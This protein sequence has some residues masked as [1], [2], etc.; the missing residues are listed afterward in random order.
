MK[1]P[2]N[3]LSKVS[4]LDSRGSYTSSLSDSLGS[5]DSLHSLDSLMGKGSLESD[6]MLINVHETKSRQPPPIKHEK[7]EKFELHKP[8]GAN[9]DVGSDWTY[10]RLRDALADLNNGF[11]EYADRLSS[12]IKYNFHI[13]GKFLACKTKVG[14]KEQVKRNSVQDKINLQEALE[15]LQAKYDTLEQALEKLEDINEDNKESITRLRAH[16]DRCIQ[17]SASRKKTIDS[18]RDE[19]TELRRQITQARSKLS[20]GS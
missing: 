14:A 19:A 7:L 8:P 18:L 10:E 9:R 3:S 5:L 13:R 17:S 2:T 12:Q 4:T 15:D 16:R 6:G 20:S 1:G 11:F